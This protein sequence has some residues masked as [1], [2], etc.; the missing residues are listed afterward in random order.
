[1]RIREKGETEVGT[2][3]RGTRSI[4]RIEEGQKNKNKERKV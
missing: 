4:E 2:E 1:M 3:R